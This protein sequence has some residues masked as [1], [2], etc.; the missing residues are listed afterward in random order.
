MEL[1]ELKKLK[2]KL[3][4]AVEKECSGLPKA[5]VM[6]SGGVDSSIVARLVLGKI[7]GTCIAVGLENSPVLKRA[8]VASE[9]L[10]L[11]L[12]SNVVERESLKNLLED[13]K[14]ITGEKGF[15]RLSIAVPELAGFRTA[16]ELECKH[17]F[18]GQGADELFFGYDY[19]REDLSEERREKSIKA[20][21]DQLKMEKKLAES[22][23]V[24]VH[25]PFLEENFVKEAL[26]IGAEKNIE[27]EDDLL[28]KRALREL[29]LEIGIP[30]EIA[31]EKKKAMQYDSGIAK[32]L[33]KII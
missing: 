32:E 13:A 29:A 1:K 14:K 3:E 9:K 21:E 2:E 8:S 24:Q 15:V 20:L 5:C 4:K 26:T 19:F 31:F 28:R 16:R 18:L 25:Y 11:K 23:G 17:V 7:S 10:C 30:K 12:A 27:G 22:T 33:K 6:F